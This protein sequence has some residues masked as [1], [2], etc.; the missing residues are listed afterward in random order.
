M[1]LEE[2]GLGYSVMVEQKF[3]R[4]MLSFGTPGHF[5]SRKRLEVVER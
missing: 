5:H 2:S 4:R 1:V 3:H